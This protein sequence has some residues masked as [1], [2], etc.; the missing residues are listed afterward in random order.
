MIKNIVTISLIVFIVLVVI[1]LGAGVFLNQPKTTT[2]TPV[3]NPVISPATNSGSI[4]LAQVAT[5]NTE[6]DCWVVVSGKVYNVTSYIP[7]HPGGPGQIIPL[8][9]GDATTAFNT[10]NGRGPHPAKAGE[11][12]NNYYVGDLSR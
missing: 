3:I 7:M 2:Q 6:S 11:V 10:R 5:H 1:I 9:G 12:L 8:C 4:T